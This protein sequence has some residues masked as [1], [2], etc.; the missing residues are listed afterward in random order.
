M[1]IMASQSRSDARGTAQLLA[2]MALDCIGNPDTAPD[3]E[4]AL[5]NVYRLLESYR[6]NA[7]FGA[8]RPVSTRAEPAAE[9]LALRRPIERHMKDVRDAIGFALR[10]TFAE[11]TTDEAIQKVEDVLRSVAYPNVVQVVPPP[12]DIRRTAQFFEEL[13]RRLTVG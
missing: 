13:I 6:T 5:N 3:Q 12:G 4:V 8:E 10:A 2:S 9:R 7:L 1:P 11:M